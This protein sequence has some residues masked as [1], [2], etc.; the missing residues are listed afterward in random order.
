MQISY[1]LTAKD[2][3]ESYVAHR[4]RNALG[5]WSRRIFIWVAAL[6]T[7][8]VLL[9]FLIKPSA[10]TAR[11]LLPFLGLVIAWIAIVWI[12]PR[13]TMR[14]Q[15]L[16]QPG[17]HGPRTLLLDSTGAHW[18]WNGGSGDV[19][20]KNYIRAVEGKN[21]ILFYTSPVCFNI[22]PKRALAGAQLDEIREFL[23]QN[24]QAPK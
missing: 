24:I 4:N 10:Q 1:E 14:R 12:R 16:K 18:R 8:I 15:F 17:A 9:G 3:S 23:K 13:W 19:E 2:F 20:W 7:A 5:K 11:S 6:C 22:L 21:Q